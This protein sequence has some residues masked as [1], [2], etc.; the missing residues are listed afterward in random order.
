MEHSDHRIQS[1]AP[2]AT[3]VRLRW[4]ALCVMVLSTGAAHY[5][6]ALADPL[7]IYAIIAVLAVANSAFALQSRAGR[8]APGGAVGQIGFDLLA[9]T[10]LLHFAGGVGNPLV[11]LYVVHAILGAMLLPRR[12]SF[13]MAG[14]GCV[15][16]KLMAL[17][18]LYGVLEHHP[19]HLVY[20]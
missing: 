13:W 9:L 17:S 14:F 4:V 3:I 18:E 16:F 19:L 6:G 2:P 8:D 1:W 10:V 20:C 15:L 7:P 11:V 5:L 12:Q